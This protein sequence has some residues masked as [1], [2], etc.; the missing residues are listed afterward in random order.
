MKKNSMKSIITSGK[1]IK[2]GDMSAKSKLS[3]GS[4]PAKMNEGSEKNR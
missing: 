3:K 1:R 2:E 4:S